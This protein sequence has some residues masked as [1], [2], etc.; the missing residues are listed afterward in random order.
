MKHS[1]TKPT[2]RK[3]FN[4][5]FTD[6]VT[7]EHKKISTG[8]ELKG[9]AEAW[10][11]QYFKKYEIGRKAG[12]APT[13]GQLVE[14]FLAAQKVEFPKQNKNARSAWETRMRDKFAHIDARELKGR[15]T[16]NYINWCVGVDHKGWSKVRSIFR[17]NGLETRSEKPL[18]KA[19]AN[20][21]IAILQG[22][23]THAKKTDDFAFRPYFHTH[24]EKENVREGFLEQWE[25]DKISAVLGEMGSEYLWLRGFVTMA[26]ECGNRRGE[27]KTL[28]VHQFNRIDGIVRLKGLDTK[29]G[30]PRELGLSAELYCL[31]AAC[32]EGKGPNDYLFTRQCYSPKTRDWAM[33]PVASFRKLWRRILAEAGIEREVLIH[34]LRRSAVGNMIQAGA[35]RDEIRMYTGHSQA[36]MHSMISRYHIL[37]RERILATAKKAEAYKLEQ[38]QAAVEVGPNLA[39]T[40]TAVM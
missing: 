6:P 35:D 9:E 7:H 16:L 23:Y 22:A 24:D 38:R 17:R 8:C 32:C 12:D 34:D 18:A 26:Y 37:R 3:Y 30:K 5:K 19:S 28:R 29:S 4:L 21:D 25:F 39:H 27:L 1:L 36:G 15:D 11:F 10:A 33:R 14:N 13:V 31:L 2:G 20:R 40:T